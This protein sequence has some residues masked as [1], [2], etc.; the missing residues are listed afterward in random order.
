MLPASAHACL[1]LSCRQI[2]SIRAEGA[3]IAADRQLIVKLQGAAYG[4]VLVVCQVRHRNSLTPEINFTDLVQN[5]I[6]L[7][8][9]AAWNITKLVGQMRLR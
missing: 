3:R 1:E 8:K 2:P 7:F 5:A 6:C 4:D 9:V